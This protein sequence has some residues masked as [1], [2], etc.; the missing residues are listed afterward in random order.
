MSK[1][2]TPLFPTVIVRTFDKKNINLL[3]LIY[4]IYNTKQF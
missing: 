4:I 2:I 3:N 1:K